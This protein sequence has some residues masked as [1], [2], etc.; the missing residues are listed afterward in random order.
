M[1]KKFGNSSRKGEKMVSTL[2]LAESRTLLRTGE[3]ELRKTYEL[4][5]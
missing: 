5:N 4:E 1:G 3:A 2:F